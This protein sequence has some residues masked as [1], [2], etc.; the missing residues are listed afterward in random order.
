MAESFESDK[1][2]RELHRE[3]KN[4]TREVTDKAISLNVLD[5]ISAISAFGVLALSFLAAAA[6]SGLAIAGMFVLGAVSVGTGIASFR[7]HH[8]LLHDYGELDEKLLDY[9]R[10]ET[11]YH[12]EYL[13]KVLD[14]GKVRDATQ[15]PSV[16][17]QLHEENAP[18][19]ADRVR[20]GDLARDPERNIKM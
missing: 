15:S 20:N 16:E 14:K 3:V 10:L 12:A 19:W 2:Y 5:A 1:S 11:K 18:G 8:N 13:G 7:Q 17:N 9:G 6:P 4:K